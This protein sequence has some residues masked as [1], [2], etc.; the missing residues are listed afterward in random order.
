M[1]DRD[2]VGRRPRETHSN[3]SCL[4]QVT[5]KGYLVDFAIFFIFGG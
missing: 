1:V 4:L 3:T 5:V 2:K